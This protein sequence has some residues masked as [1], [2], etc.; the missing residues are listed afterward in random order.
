[1]KIKWL[2]LLGTLFVS[3]V[4]YSQNAVELLRPIHRA[5]SAILVRKINVPITV[6]APALRVARLNP[7]DNCA[8]KTSAFRV[9]VELER[10]IA[11][12]SLKD[13][14]RVYGPYKFVKTVSRASQNPLLVNEQYIDNWKHINTVG[15]YNGVHHLISKSTIKR[16]YQDLKEQGEDVRLNE[17]ENNSP[18]IFHPLHGDSDFRDVFHDTDQ[19]YYDYKRFGMKVTIISLLER[20]DELNLKFGLPPYPEQYLDGVLKEAELWSKYWKIRWE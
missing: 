11:R 5:S 8:V 17:M 19:Q 16:I 2:L 7:K 12:N 9:E 20:I 4:C 14:V 3:G 15:Y 10:E 1:M 18:A 13:P 6:G